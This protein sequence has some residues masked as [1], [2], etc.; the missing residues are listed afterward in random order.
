MSE[1][2]K[3]V[4]FSASELRQRA[5]A[6]LR[7]N[8]AQP[9]ESLTELSLEETQELLH[10]L[11]VDQIEM[12]M[13]N[14]EL[15][16]AQVKLEESKA[17]Y[18]EL[19][20]LAPV[21]YCTVDQHGLVQESNLAAATLLGVARGN[22][23]GNPFHRTI[24]EED[25]G[26][27]YLLCKRLVETAEPQE[28]ELR[29]VRQG[30]VPFWAHLRTTIAQ[31]EGSAPL[32]RLVITDINERKK[33]EELRQ[34]AMTELREASLY[35]RNLLETSLDPLVTISPEGKVSDVNTATERV[36]GL[37][38]DRLIGS[39]FADYFTDPEMA[40]AGY[41]KAFSDG[42]VIDYHL[43]IRHAS[44]TI[45]EVLYNA[46]VYRNERGE[47]LGVFAA[48]RDVTERKKAEEEFRKVSG[49]FKSV[50][51]NS[52]EII[53]M[54]DA[55]HCYVLFNS[56]L[57]EEYK[58]IFGWDLKFGDS[59]NDALA[60]HPDDLANALKL[61]DR[62]LA[63][64]DFTVIQEF[65]DVKL[66]RN[67]YELHFSPVRDSDGKVVNAV[68]VVRN[69]NERKLAE[70]ALSELQERLALAMDQSQLAY[71]EMDA[72]TNTF[73]FNDRYY[74]LHGTTAEREGG[75]QM[76]VDVAIRELLP[77]EDRSVVADSIL[78][79][80]SGE[81][82]ELQLEH[83]ILRRDG[84]LRHVQ[85][86]IHLIRDDTG[87]ITG[88]RGS[89]L[90]ITERKQMEER[91]EK[92]TAEMERFTYT[93]SH[94]LKSPLVTIKTFLGYLEKDLNAQKSERV[95][96][97][98][99][100]IHGA[101]DKM[102]EL[103][104]E[105]LKLA[106]VGYNAN[107]IVN[108]PLQQVV[109]EALSLVAGQLAERRVQVQITQDPVWLTGDR[110]RLVEVFQNLIDNAVKFLGGQPAPLVEIGVESTA[111]EIMI[112]VRDNGKGIDLPHQSKV[113]ALFH[114]IDDCA[115][116][117]GLGLA[118]VRRI[119]ELHGGKIWVESD[120]AGH[121]TT[122]RFTLAKTQLRQPTPSIT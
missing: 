47:V 4:E 59:I 44:G 48:A 64:E 28:C 75:Y 16:A 120:G 26:R 54:M 37:S 90:D 8:A 9:P 46:S 41:K 94:D 19:Y 110:A 82:T 61:W 121:G 71:W 100:F 45:T 111:G 102:G 25:D 88:A 73:T 53:A 65:G 33:A 108:V 49:Q 117:S 76:P 66:L 22:L 29:M 69:I 21:G 74:A 58:R 15:R 107:D 20:D 97:D 105:L 119:V 85:V 11:R 5:E 1:P 6:S 95:A 10:E 89:N 55:E 113:F 77:S 109:Q 2:H 31:S 63:G 116:G 17:R 51:E 68:H 106:R 70:V 27:F 122:F 57:H 104:N 67:W 118:L 12:E 50:I 114:Q 35:S 36:T 87:R 56:A 39:D 43:A 23:V 62:A 13:Q 78:K 40:R 32:I 52:M 3:N 98:L 30:G 14:E 93:V 81:G 115:P 92:K 91:L 83:R 24:H 112:F 60:A 86:R 84:E 72:A 34:K 18:F 79:G 7:E 103:L 101:A 80:L 38:R 99:G 42:Q 96:R